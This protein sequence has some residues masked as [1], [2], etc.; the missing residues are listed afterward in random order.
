[1]VIPIRIKRNGLGIMEIG[2]D[3]LEMGRLLP[4]AIYE[5]NNLLV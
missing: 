3:H 2:G 5:Y 4:S 1:M